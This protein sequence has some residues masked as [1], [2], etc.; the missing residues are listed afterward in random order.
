MRSSPLLV[1][2]LLLPLALGSCLRD[3]AGDVAI[4]ISDAGDL[5]LFLGLCDG[6]DLIGARI[7]DPVDGVVG[8]DNDVVHWQIS[9][10]G[11]AGAPPTGLVVGD[12]VAGFME[13]TP[14]DAP[15]ADEP[16]TFLVE[17][18]REGYVGDFP[19]AEMS[20]HLVTVSGARQSIDEFEESVRSDCSG[21][22][23]A[24]QMHGSGPP[25]TISQHRLSLPRT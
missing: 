11:P 17:T 4:G 15:S 16:L 14:W 18:V 7:A 9:R 6:D 8:D 25:D 20:D 10:D 12:E 5:T 1:P 24:G 19:L 2:L 13:E 3:P 21:P 23:R 22:S